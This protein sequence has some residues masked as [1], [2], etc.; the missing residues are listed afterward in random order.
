MIRTQGYIVDVC[1]DRALN[2][3]EKNKDTPF[4]CYIPFSTPH[5]PWASP[6]ENWA[7]FKDKPIQLRGSDAEKEVLDE[8]RCAL[9]MIENQDMNVG[10]VLAKLK[11]HGLNENTIIVYFSD[12]GPNSMRWTGGMKGKKATTDEGGVRSVC[13]LRWPAQLP[14]GHTMTQIAGAIDLMPTLISFAG[15]KRVGDKPLD[16]RD[17]SPLLLNQKIL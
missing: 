11:D 14:A 9:S 17:L 3:I 10:R 8:T 1:T 13:Y 7:R 12:N 15:I 5:S 4:V 16:G 2:F 6:A